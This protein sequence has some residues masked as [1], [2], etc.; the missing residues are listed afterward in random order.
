MDGENKG[1]H[2]KTLLK[3]MLWGGPNPYICSDIYPKIRENPI[4]MGCLGGLAQPPIFGNTQMKG[5]STFS[6]SR[7]SPYPKHSKDNAAAAPWGVIRSSRT[8]A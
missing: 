5:T 2:G 3:L 4:K 8:R 1:K 7:S 6:K